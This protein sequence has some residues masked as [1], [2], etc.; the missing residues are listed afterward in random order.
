MAR[1][2]RFAFLYSEDERRLIDL[3]S[4]KLGR[5]RSDTIRILVFKAARELADQEYQLNQSEQTAQ[6]GSQD[7]SR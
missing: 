5:T 3:V 2:K 6:E 7:A 4:L 1:M